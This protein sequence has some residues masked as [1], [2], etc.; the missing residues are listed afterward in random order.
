M[1]RFVLINWTQICTPILSYLSANFRS[2][3]ILYHDPSWHLKKQSC[4]FP[5]VSYPLNCFTRG[6]LIHLALYFSL[7]FLFFDI[8][9][10]IEAIKYKLVCDI[11]HIL[12]STFPFFLFLFFLDFIQCIR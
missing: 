3:N 10:V 6:E 11:G 1:I 4:L 8:R 12:N 5:L 9:S 7:C 2:L